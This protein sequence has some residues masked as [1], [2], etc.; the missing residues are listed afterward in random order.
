MPESVRWYVSWKAPDCGIAVS[1]I[2]FFIC[3][4]QN[5]R[6]DSAALNR[7]FGKRGI[8][9]QIYLFFP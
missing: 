8:L 1:A 7:L 9:Y 3:D 5:M 4:T 2:P 6:Q